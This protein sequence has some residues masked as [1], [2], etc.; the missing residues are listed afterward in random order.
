MSLFD[1][2][3]KKNL[4]SLIFGVFIGYKLLPIAWH[5]FYISAIISLAFMAF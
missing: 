1:K 4:A 2:E 5:I 3:D